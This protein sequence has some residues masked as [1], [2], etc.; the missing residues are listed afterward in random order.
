MSPYSP[1]L[2]QDLGVL[3]IV[4]SSPWCGMDTFQPPSRSP[5]AFTGLTGFSDAGYP[6]TQLFL[7]K[8]H[9]ELVYLILN[10]KDKGLYSH[11]H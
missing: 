6:C 2:Q 8:V 10:S 4:A 7:I 5:C 1:I 9:C 3:W 11:L